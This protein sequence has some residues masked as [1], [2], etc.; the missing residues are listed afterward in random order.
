MFWP[1]LTLSPFSN[2]N[3]AQVRINRAVVIAVLENHHI[4]KAVLN[5][6]EIYN[7]IANTANSGAC[8]GSVIKRPD[9]PARFAGWGESAS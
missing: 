4:A 8:R 7:T 2:I 6:S 1:W 9:G 5:A 3:F